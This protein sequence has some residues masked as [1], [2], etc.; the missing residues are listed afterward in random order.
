VANSVTNISQKKLK[1]I[2]LLQLGKAKPLLSTTSGGRN[3]RKPV[4]TCSKST[5][6]KQLRESCSQQMNRQYQPNHLFLSPRI[7]LNLPPATEPELPPL[8]QEE[9][10]IVDQKIKARKMIE[11]WIKAIYLSEIKKG[12]KVEDPNYFFIITIMLFI[13]FDD[14]LQL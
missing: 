13:H 11:R 14:E 10:H 2:F 5:S 7:D 12:P 8:T 4:E 3:T 6:R 9:I 1:Y